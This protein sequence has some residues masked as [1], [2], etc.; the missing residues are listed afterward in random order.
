MP[1]STSWAFLFTGLHLSCRAVHIC[2]SWPQRSSYLLHCT[3]ENILNA[4]DV[5]GGFHIWHIISR[6]T[7]SIPQSN[8]GIFQF[9][10]L[11]LRSRI[12]C[13]SLPGCPFVG[14]IRTR[15]ATRMLQSTSGIFL[16]TA[17]YIRNH[18]LYRSQP[19]RRDISDVPLYCIIPIRESSLG[20]SIGHS[21]S[22]RTTRM[23]QSTWL[24]FPITAL[25]LRKHPECHSCL[26]RFP[27]RTHY[28]YK[29]YLMPQ[30]TL[31]IFLFTKLYLWA[32]VICPNCP[33]R[34]LSRTHQN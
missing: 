22:R 30:L 17:L 21:R 4:A 23:L 25:Y 19:I 2:Y 14:Y 5:V 20:F 6:I 10:E 1:Q 9:T 15:R 3:L 12:I 27:Y 32:R 8:S 28:I 16:F 11:Y 26:R 29:N 31:V 24:I 7:I 33:G 34:S 13:L 18:T